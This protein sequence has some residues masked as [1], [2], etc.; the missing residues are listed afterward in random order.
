MA[1]EDK[2]QRTEEATP[3]KK[4]K[5]RQEGQMAKSPD[6]GA[7]AVLFAAIAALG[8][9]GA[10]A[11]MQ[12]RAFAERCFRLK[13]APLEALEGVLPT[14]THSLLP[15]LV[16][17][18]V[19]A[20]V[21]GV[22][23]TKG[24]F[25]LELLALKPERLNPIPK[26][27][28]VFPSKTTLLELGKQLLKVIILGVVVAQLILSSRADLGVL[29]FTTPQVS[30]GLV[31][32]VVTKV[33]V[34][35]GMVFAALSVLDYYIAVRR[36]NEESKMSKEDI[37]DEH[38]AQEGRPEVKAN[39]RRRARELARNR[40]VGDVKNATVLVCN[41]THVAIALR[42]DAELTPAPVVLAKGVEEVALEMRAEARSHGIPVVE[43][44]PLARTLLKTSKVGQ[45]IPVD[46]YKAVA[47]VIAHIMRIR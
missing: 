13:D 18:F 29:A 21:A 47:E 22:V 30:A 27:K 35:G 24:L 8:V 28:S 19:A 41:P 4:E 9:F 40:A 33:F 11:A 32:G 25:N 20:A 39:R 38:K 3:K 31:A 34:Y 46:L 45:T 37:K 26:L 16:A 36:H 43:N 10:Q 44:R 17:G 5:L 7:A 23:Q 12:A 6:I 2:D 14:V 15:V 1:S 42:Y